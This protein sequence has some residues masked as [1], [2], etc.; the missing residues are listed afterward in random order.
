MTGGHTLQ[1]VDG[2]ILVD[3]NA[4]F[5]HPDLAALRDVD[6]EAPSE[7]EARQRGLSYI[8]LDGEIGCMVNGAGLAM[9][10]MDMTQVVWRQPRQLPGHRRR[11]AGR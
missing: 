6:E 10:T 4:L 5:R 3:D 2:K 11:R 1:A 7:T 8:K 9:A